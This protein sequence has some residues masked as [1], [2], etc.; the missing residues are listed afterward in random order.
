VLPV[1]YEPH[2]YIESK[3][4]YVTGRGG[5]WNCEML[6]FPHCPHSRL[7]DGDELVSLTRPP[8]SALRKHFLFLYIIFIS[9]T[10]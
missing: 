8:H 3:D 7:K 9:V 6:K 4:I 2:L 5:L 10:D 1:K